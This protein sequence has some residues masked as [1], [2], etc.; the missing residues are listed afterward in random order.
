MKKI[1]L[2]HPMNGLTDDE[3]IKL[4]DQMIDIAKVV[5]D[6]GDLEVVNSYFCDK[7]EDTTTN[8]E[9][10]M[11]LGKSVQVMSD[12]DVVVAVEVYDDEIGRR[13]NIEITIARQY[14]IPVIVLNYHM[15]PWLE[16]KI[17]DIENA[18][19]EKV[20][21]GNVNE[22]PS[23]DNHINY[24]GLTGNENTEINKDIF[25]EV[26]DSDTNDSIDMDFIAVGNENTK[27]I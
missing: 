24:E 1:F 4:R 23:W 25:S 20:D 8:A 19:W 14:D 2:A 5:L 7:R 26:S 6:S 13:S 18:R 3:I 16:K 9:A 27:E 10:I 15:F 11:F 22:T 17:L 12:A 21:I